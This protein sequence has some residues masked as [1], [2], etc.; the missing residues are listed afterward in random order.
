MATNGVALDQEPPE[1]VLVQVAELPTHSGDVPVI[2]CAV[3]ALTVTVDTPLG[4]VP[5]ALETRTI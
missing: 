4:V 1:V 2:V 3:A 5:N